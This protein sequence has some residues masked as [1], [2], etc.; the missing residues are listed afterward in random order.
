M[1][2]NAQGPG[3]AALAQVTMAGVLDNQPKVGVAGKVDGQLNLAH[4]AD[5]HGIHRIASSGAVPAHGV[6]GWH[7]CSAL[8][9]RPEDGRWIVFT[10][11]VSM[12]EVEKDALAV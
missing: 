1:C 8:V 12:L 11:P 3:T 9:L 6:I 2:P 7:A 5:I 4:V 10:G